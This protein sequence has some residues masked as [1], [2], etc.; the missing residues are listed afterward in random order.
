MLY[1]TLGTSLL[2]S[3]T[4]DGLLKSRALVFVSEIFVK[5]KIYIIN[6]LRVKEVSVENCSDNPNV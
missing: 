2:N 5:S 1:C 4:G 6:R 3:L